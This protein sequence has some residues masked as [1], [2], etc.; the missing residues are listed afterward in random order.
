MGTFLFAQA[1]QS[2]IDK[3]QIGINASKFIVLFNEQVNNL[4]ISYRY[5]LSDSR[6]IRIASSVDISTEEGDFAN[7]EFRLGYDFNYK[8]TDK[9]RFYPGADVTFGQSILRSADRVNTSIGLLGF[10]GIQFKMGKHFSLSTEPSLAVY[11]KIRKDPNSFD[12]DAN[13]QWMEVKLLNMGQ[14]I[15]SFHF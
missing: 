13:D 11:G 5:S 4:D 12:P 15:V 10:F 3:H 7:Y 8:E 14:I 2:L 1:D 6:R 9:W